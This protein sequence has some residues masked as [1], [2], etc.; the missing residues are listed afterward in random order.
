MPDINV[1]LNKIIT[2]IVKDSASKVIGAVYKL[3]ERNYE[4]ALAVFELCFTKYLGRS[5]ERYSVIK[6]LLYRD[7]PVSIKKHFVKPDISVNKN[8]IGQND[9]D[10]FITATRYL[11]ISGTAGCG[12]ST[13]MKSLF[14]RFVEDEFDGLPIFI[15]LRHLNAAAYISLHDYI[16]GI[17][18]DV[19]PE[20]T[21]EQ[22]DYSLKIGK[23]VLFLDG[24]DEI[25]YDS[26]HKYEK[27]IVK[28]CNSYGKIKIIISSRPDDIFDSWEE[29]TRAE[30][31]PFD[32]IKAIKLVEKLEYD[33][34]TKSKFLN[35]LNGELFERHM[36]FLSNPLLL[37]MMMLTYEQ[38]AEI[39]DK[40]HIFYN[41]AFDTL[42]HK[43]DALKSLYKR[44]S[45]TG[46]A[47]DDFKR[48][49]SAFSI[50]SYA[51]NK[52]S[53]SR[54]EALNYIGTAKKL[55]N[56]SPNKV[57]YINDLIESVCILM[58]DGIFYT[59]THR[60]FQEY[61]TAYFI[62]NTESV[63]K[64]QLIDKIFHSSNSI[65]E[66][67]L[68]MLFA[69]NSEL[70]EEH[71]IRPRLKKLLSFSQKRSIKGQPLKFFDKIL[72]GIMI[73]KDHWVLYLD[74]ENREGVFLLFLTQIYKDLADKHYS[75]YQDRGKNL[76]IEIL[77]KTFPGKNNVTFKDAQL[78]RDEK[79]VVDSGI[80]GRYEA[81]LSF[82]KELDEYLSK[83]R[84]KK[85]QG[86]VA[87]LSK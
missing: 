24:Y 13:Y 53:F 49:L 59:F 33:E 65:T 32:K 75:E 9:H 2:S 43:H 22:L 87:L 64:E 85:Q 82:I 18:K 50:L 70:I 78:I 76:E 16:F 72:S 55:E 37:T 57:E 20:F 41:Q 58:K 67:V 27:E 6:T 54:E 62:A 3:G 83:K 60:S 5:Y 10:D 47:V 81:E 63:D 36:D 7:K 61:F 45:H 14:L 35:E 69:M 11:V 44:K 30:I 17:L 40:I 51:D 68:S 86:L 23:I 56:L 8:V 84:E 71:W 80:Q 79:W 46:L 28:F 52:Y 77:K 1:D 42:F 73:D 4:K 38:L 31:L 66:N 15:E 39:P 12:K 25:N 19:N 48:L 34:E 26:R 21:K 74:H 29:F